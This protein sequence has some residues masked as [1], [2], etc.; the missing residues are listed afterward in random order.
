M[1]WG[2]TP[3]TS[4]TLR[5][6]PLT[7]ESP[8][9]PPCTFPVPSAFTSSRKASGHESSP[10]LSLCTMSQ[11]S[12]NHPYV[13]LPH[14]G[15]RSP[16][17][18]VTCVLCQW[19]AHACG[20][21]VCRASMA[22]WWQNCRE[23]WA[24]SEELEKGRLWMCSCSGPPSPAAIQEAGPGPCRPSII[25]AKVQ[26]LPLLLTRRALHTG[27]GSSCGLKGALW[28]SRSWLRE[29]KGT[30][31]WKGH[32]R[33]LSSQTRVPVSLLP[34]SAES[35]AVVSNPLPALPV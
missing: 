20:G 8:W 33:D 28:V 17:Q 27:P 12:L 23:S 3:D 10:S 11:C 1:L 34:N 14:C 22:L 35:S 30:K 29:G 4:W 18:P 21:A 25:K 7:S 31:I 15:L 13:Q 16:R 32:C 5:P 24:G 9:A 19:L 26:L 6:T 2:S